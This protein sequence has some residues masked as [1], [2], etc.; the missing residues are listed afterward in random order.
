MSDVDLQNNSIS[1]D[2]K[3]SSWGFSRICLIVFLFIFIYCVSFG[4]VA[5]VMLKA[6]KSGLIKYTNVVFT[7]SIIFYSPHLKAM[8]LCEGYFNYMNWWFEMGGDKIPGTFNDFKNSS[9]F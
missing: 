2:S 8:R 6:E 9:Y 5:F 1:D 4:P 7:G 3:A